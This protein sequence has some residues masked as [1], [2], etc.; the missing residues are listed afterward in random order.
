MF[1]GMI[2]TTV[3]MIQEIPTMITPLDPDIETMLK[4]HMIT[5]TT[6]IT[7]VTTTTA[8]PKVDREE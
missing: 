5:T 8:E 2:V 3:I 6:T 4:N 7:T 1:T